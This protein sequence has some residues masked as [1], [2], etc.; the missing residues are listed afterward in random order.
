MK[1]LILLLL[2]IVGVGAGCRRLLHARSGPEPSAMT[3]PVTRGDVV[4]VVQATGALEAV[5]TVD[6]GTQVSG[7]VQDMYADFNRS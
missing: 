7:L 4:D 3:M 5:T 2:V 1:K 6:V